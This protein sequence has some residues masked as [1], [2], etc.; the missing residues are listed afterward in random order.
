MHLCKFSRSEILFG[1][2]LDEC[3]LDLTRTEAKQCQCRKRLYNV[4]PADL[5]VLS[6]TYPDD[7]KGNPVSAIKQVEFDMTETAEAKTETSGGGGYRRPLFGI[8]DDRP[9]RIPIFWQCRMLLEV[10]WHLIR[11]VKRTWT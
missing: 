9:L 1:L 6:C 8:L 5:R 11:V 3:P 7:W 4:P 10:R 2:I